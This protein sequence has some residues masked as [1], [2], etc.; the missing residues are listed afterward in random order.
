MMLTFRRAYL[1]A[2]S[3]VSGAQLAECLLE[4]NLFVTIVVGKVIHILYPTYFSASI[5]VFQINK[6]KGN[7]HPKTVT[8]CVHLL[9]SDKCTLISLQLCSSINLLRRL[10]Q[11]TSGRLTC[12]SLLMGNSRNICN[13]LLANP[14]EK[15]INIVIFLESKGGLNNVR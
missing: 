7:K 10:K 13:S 11:G 2:I 1:R 9:T 12:K 14:N 3:R 6:E 8:L 15:A 4:Q 5:A